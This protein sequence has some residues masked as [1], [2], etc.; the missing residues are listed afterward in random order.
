MKK[1]IIGLFLIS[2][3]YLLMST[4][5]EVILIPKEAIR[6]RVIANSDSIKDQIEKH[7]LIES[8][9][10]I[11]NDIESK[12]NNLEESR[13][14]IKKSIPD[15]NEKIESFNLKAK[16]SYGMNYFPEKV[17]KN[18]MYEEGNYE[19]LV[20]EIGQGYGENWW[21]VLFPPL[22]MMENKNLEEYDYSLYVKNII[23]KYL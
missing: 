13:N 19:S 22:C 20:I 9:E 8:I 11:I 2:S 17:Y 15:I 10:N 16:I 23:D 6:L 1:V 4:K 14:L 18:T 12:S 5:N 3:A 21:C 7:R